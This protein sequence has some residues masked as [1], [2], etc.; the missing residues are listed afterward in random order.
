MSWVRRRIVLRT[1]FKNRNAV[2][3]VQ[4]IFSLNLH[5]QNKCLEFMAY[6]ALQTSTFYRYVIRKLVW[7]LECFENSTEINRTGN[8][9]IHKFLLFMTLGFESTRGGRKVP[10][11]PFWVVYGHEYSKYV[12]ST[13]VSFEIYWLDKRKPPIEI[14]RQFCCPLSLFWNTLSTANNSFILSIL[15]IIGYHNCFSIFFLYG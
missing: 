9:F 7:I 6:T 4:I 8:L 2:K 13:N 5:L 3:Q 1:T 14:L 10:D 11:L 12:I 15:E